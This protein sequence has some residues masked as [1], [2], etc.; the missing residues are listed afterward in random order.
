M[1][2][3]QRSCVHKRKG[4]SRYRNL[5]R[6]SMY[7]YESFCSAYFDYRAIESSNPEGTYK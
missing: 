6:F 1:K 2:L 5:E 7:W 3:H 4:E